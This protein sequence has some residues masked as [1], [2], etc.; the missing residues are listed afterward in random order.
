MNTR[1]LQLG[2]QLP[3]L[4]NALAGTL[5]GGQKRRLSAAIAL[6]GGSKVVPWKEESGV[7]VLLKVVLE[8]FQSVSNGFMPVFW[9]FRAIFAFSKCFSDNTSVR[10][11]SL[12]CGRRSMK[13]LYFSSVSSG[14]SCSSVGSLAPMTLSNSGVLMTCRGLLGWDLESHREN[15]C[16]AWDIWLWVKTY[17]VPFLWG[18]LPPL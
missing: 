14:P 4:R 6:I 17:S 16:F 8:W 5:S 10:H 13:K 1:F 3:Q 15:R 11:Q 9:C 12:W 2:P 18:S 7:M